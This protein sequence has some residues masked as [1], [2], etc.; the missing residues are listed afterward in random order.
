[1]ELYHE[2]WVNLDEEY[3]T[4]YDETF[5]W[6]PIF[7]PIVQDLFLEEAE[8]LVDHGTGP[9]WIT[10]ELAQRM[11]QNSK[12]Y[13][14]DISQQLL[15]LA[16]LH[17]QEMGLSEKVNWCHITDGKIPLPD[18][19]ADRIFSKNTMAYVPS[20]DEV[21]TEFRRV[22]KPGG[23]VRII[24]ND[25][26]LFAVEPCDQEMF[27][28]FMEHAKN[29][30]CDPQAGRHLY[31]AARRAGFKDVQV[32]VLPIVDTMG[33]TFDIPLKSNLEIAEQS[34]FP[35]EKA[36]RFIMDCQKALANQELLIMMT[37]FI[38]TATAP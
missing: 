19:D 31:G 9:G 21:L 18:G 15:K 2:H 25:W 7:E 10:L 3:L 14:C 17:G 34:G 8:C 22:L 16:E 5:K 29:I 38:I 28:S 1:M 13:G 20:I 37:L 12:V 6:F 23:I 35:S 27:K 24:E 11:P 32:S 4:K 33:F 36:D 30:W 26:D